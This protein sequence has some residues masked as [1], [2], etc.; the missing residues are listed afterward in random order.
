MARALH[1]VDAGAVISGFADVIAAVAEN[2]SHLQTV[3]NGIKRVST[4]MGMR[5][6]IDKAGRLHI[7]LT[8]Q[9]SPR[10]MIKTISLPLA[11]HI[12]R[13]KFWVT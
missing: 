5:I 11:L 3:V 1:D 10:V 13:S 4:K 7:V 9:S 8:R 6:N 12:V 2:E